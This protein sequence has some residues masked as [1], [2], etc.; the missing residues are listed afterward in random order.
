V[1]T[2]PTSFST[3]LDAAANDLDTT[4]NNAA[5]VLPKLA[6]AGLFRVG[7]PSSLG[8]HG[9]DVTDAVAAIAAVSERSLAAGFVFWGHRSFIEYLLQ[10]PNSAFRD[11]QLPD[12]LSG[13]RAGATGLSNAMKFLS[14]IEGLQIKAAKDNDSLFINGQLPWVTNLR[15]PRFRCC[16]SRA[17][18]RQQPCFRR[19]PVLR[20]CRP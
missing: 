20:R 2:L 8:G 12:L 7:V 18:R 16:R 4:L 1:T 14:G 10:S 15:A 19:Q 5:A 17:G 3:W 13:K 6:E 9:G 11:R